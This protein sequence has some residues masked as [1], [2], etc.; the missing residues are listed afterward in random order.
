MIE[1]D[2]ETEVEGSM[3]VNTSMTT[4]QEYQNIEISTE[5]KSKSIEMSS[6]SCSENVVVDI[7]FEKQRETVDFSVS[8]EVRSIEVGSEIYG[9]KINV[10]VD[11]LTTYEANLAMDDACCDFI[12][13][14]VDNE[15]YSETIFRQ[16]LCSQE[17]VKSSEF[18][19]EMTSL[20]V[21]SSSEFSMKSIETGI[22]EY[23]NTCDVGTEACESTIIE[24]MSSNEISYLS[25]DC[26]TVEV[27]EEIV[28]DSEDFQQAEMMRTEDDEICCTISMSDMSTDIRCNIIDSCEEMDV[29]SIECGIEWTEQIIEEDEVMETE[30]I[31][32]AESSISSD[33]EYLTIDT[34]F[35]E[36]KT[37]SIETGCDTK[38]EIVDCYNEYKVIISLIAIIDVK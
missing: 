19:V 24:E 38:P 16:D 13:I 31:D 12:S 33:V 1:R 32:V 2:S 26:E 35:D 20:T 14:L 29:S 11:S 34:Q 30:I 22:E 5:F 3:L 8:V 36:R 15:S 18:G 27:V 10:V 28:A 17:E 7:G 9:E 6:E 21:E 25:V 4:E 37:I 23:Q